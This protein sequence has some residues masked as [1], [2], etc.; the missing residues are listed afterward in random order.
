V[1]DFI[2]ESY[3]E[4]NITLNTKHLYVS[5][6]V[7]LS[8]ALDHKK[9]FEDMDIAQGVVSGFL[10]SYKRPFEATLTS[11]GLALIIPER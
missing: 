7:Y 5:T 3:H 2:I 9:A 11:A 10:N 6:L 4:R 8:R 1:A